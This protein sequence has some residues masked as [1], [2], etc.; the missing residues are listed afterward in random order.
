MESYSTRAHVSCS[1][2]ARLDVA[3]HRL[4]LHGWLCDIATGQ[5]DTPDDARIAGVRRGA[6]S[7]SV[8]GL[9]TTEPSVPFGKLEPDRFR[10]EGGFQ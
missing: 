8:P 4:S 5:V 2:E 3:Q 7:L 10:C 1:S 9:R 6:P